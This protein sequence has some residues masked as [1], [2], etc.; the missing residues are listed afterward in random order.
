MVE[1]IVTHAEIVA[2][3]TAVVDK[4]AAHVLLFPKIRYIFGVRIF[5]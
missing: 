2:P 4:I 1:K 3:P 5:V